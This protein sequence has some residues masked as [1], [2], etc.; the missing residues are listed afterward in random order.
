VYLQASK[1]SSPDWPANEQ[2]SALANWEQARQID[3]DNRLLARMTRQR[4]EGEAIRDAMLAAAERVS[5]RREGPGVRPPL[6]AE[7]SAT[8]LNAKQ[9]VV[10]PNEEDHR[11]R[12]IYLFVR[13]NLRYPLFEAFDRP[14]TNA[15]C[16][17]RNRSTIAP[18]A[19]ILLNSEFSL[20]AARDL[21]GY[22]ISHAGNDAGK[23]ILLGYERTLGRPPAAD[24]HAVALRF[25]ADEATKLKDSGRPLSD[26]AIPRALPTGFDSYSAAALTD[27]CLALFNLNE[28]VY[29]D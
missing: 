28:F 16:P 24:E 29:V 8:L 4:L 7:V 22:L 23:Q 10:S 19:L 20:A 27:F 25:L 2:S 18:Q 1:P 5:P 3:P 17:R 11:R 21:A 12:S 6:P 9:W 14:D 13:R 15:S 26:L